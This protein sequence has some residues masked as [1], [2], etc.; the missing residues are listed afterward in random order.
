M[1]GR[2]LAMVRRRVGTSWRAPLATRSPAAH[3]E[4]TSASGIGGVC[5]VT[6]TGG[7]VRGRVSIDTSR[8]SGRTRWNS[9][10]SRSA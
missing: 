7:V 8:T 5:A 4:A 3:S 2:V 6:T 1:T 9:I 10:A